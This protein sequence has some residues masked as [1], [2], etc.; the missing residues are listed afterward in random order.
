MLYPITP[1][2]LNFSSNDWTFS[3]EIKR[4]FNR[5][6]NYMMKTKLQLLTSNTFLLF[7][8]LRLH[9]LTHFTLQTNLK[10]I[11]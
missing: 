10:L 8:T 11:K 2:V 1:G 4:V 5:N 9:E 3:I 6:M 7:F